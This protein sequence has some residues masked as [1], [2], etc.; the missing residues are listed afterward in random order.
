MD[1]SSSYSNAPSTPNQRCRTHACSSPYHALRTLSNSSTGS[2]HCADA[3][4]EYTRREGNGRTSDDEGT[5]GE[6]RLIPNHES[7]HFCYLRRYLLWRW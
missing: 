5:V 1:T 4:G 6:M 3:V 7:P 2:W